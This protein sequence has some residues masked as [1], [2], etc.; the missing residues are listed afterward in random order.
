M[1][2]WWLVHMEEEEEEVG[3]WSVLSSKV[4]Q[5]LAQQGV[6]LFQVLYQVGLL[7]HHLL[8]TGAFSVTQ[9]IAHKLL[10]CLWITIVIYYIVLMSTKPIKG[11]KKKDQ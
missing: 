7:L 11:Q 5:P 4:E 2:V 8:Q 6:V 3:L 10:I 9:T 1:S